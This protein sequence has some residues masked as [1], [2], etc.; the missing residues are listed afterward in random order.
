[1]LENV[2]PV[3]AKQK[4]AQG[5][6]RRPE[7]GAF[8][9]EGLGKGIATLSR[10]GRKRISQSLIRQKNGKTVTDQKGERMRF[11]SHLSI[12]RSRA[13]RRQPLSN[14]LTYHY[15]FMHFFSSTEM[16]TANQVQDIAK[17]GIEMR[18]EFSIRYFRNPPDP[19]SRVSPA[20]FCLLRS[21]PLLQHA[22][23]SESIC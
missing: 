14:C 19:S 7:G 6:A 13:W 4:E 22:D 8:E 3:V 23:Q 2:E 16:P 20:I 11:P 5:Q 9:L 12:G 15:T 17:H 18:L 21:C 1:M 10:R